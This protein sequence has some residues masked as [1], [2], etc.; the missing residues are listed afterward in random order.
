MSNKPQYPSQ[1]RGTTLAL[2]VTP[3]QRERWKEAATAQGLTLN[4][5]AIDALNSA[6]S[7]QQQ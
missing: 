4:R 3:E 2:R 6:V 1:G 5:W 7:R